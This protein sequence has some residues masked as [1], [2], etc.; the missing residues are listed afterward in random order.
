[1]RLLA[2]A[3]LWRRGFSRDD[4]TGIDPRRHCDCESIDESLPERL[5]RAA[6]SSPR[7]AAT[8]KSKRPGKAGP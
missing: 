8:R 6:R 4:I 5:A 3:A 7:E 2:A 1:M